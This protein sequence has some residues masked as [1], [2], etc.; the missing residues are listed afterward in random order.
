MP[1]EKVLQRRTHNA[2]QPFL[3]LKNYAPL[4]DRKTRNE[5]TDISCTLLSLQP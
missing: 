1:R 5:A 4:Q 2:P 3:T